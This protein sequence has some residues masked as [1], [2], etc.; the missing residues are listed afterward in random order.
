MLAY[1]YLNS[2]NLEGQT[3]SQRASKRNI[4]T[5]INEEI[6]TSSTLNKLYIEAESNLNF[7]ES[8]M[9]KYSYNVGFGIAMN[10]SNN[11][12]PYYIITIVYTIRDLQ[13]TP[14]TPT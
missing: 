10:T 4:I 3:L 9:N 1:S 5:Y 14:A 11:K 2:T 13:E 7:K 6:K 8:L 12:T